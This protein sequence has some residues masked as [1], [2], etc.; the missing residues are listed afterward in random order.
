MRDTTG[1]HEVAE[2]TRQGFYPSESGAFWI[3]DADPRE[4][5][6]NHITPKARAVLAAATLSGGSGT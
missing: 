3:R 5:L 4:Y 2:R 6:N 1:E